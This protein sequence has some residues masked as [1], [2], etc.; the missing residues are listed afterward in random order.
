M[1][2]WRVRA[3]NQRV[4]QH[5][6]ADLHGKSNRSSG[7]LAAHE[8]RR[9]ARHIAPSKG[10]A[11]YVEAVLEVLRKLFDEAR[12]EGRKI[13]TGLGE[14]DWEEPSSAAVENPTPAG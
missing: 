7:Q 6:A 5:D 10:L 2:Q 8:V 12:Q 13:V 1:A 11:S 3:V 9:K 14:R 4:G